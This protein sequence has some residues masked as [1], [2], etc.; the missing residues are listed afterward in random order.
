MIV[1]E[2]WSFQ[3]IFRVSSFTSALY[4]HQIKILLFTVVICFIDATNVK[5]PWTLSFCWFLLQV[6]VWDTANV[7]G[8]HLLILVSCMQQGQG[9]LTS[10]NLLI[11]LPL[12]WMWHI[13]PYHFLL[14]I[15]V[16]FRWL[17]VVYPGCHFCIVPF[18]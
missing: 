11:S 6:L 16:I 12:V 2:K 15:Y 10:F 1:S 8:L 5:C 17:C 4:I 14:M 3:P 9:M 18:N 7:A 13:L